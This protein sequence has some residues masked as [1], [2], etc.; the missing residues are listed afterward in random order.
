MKTQKQIKTPKIP[1]AVLDVLGKPVKTEVFNS[2]NAWGFSGWS[3]T[4]THFENPLAVWEVGRASTRH[5]G[6][7]PHKGVRVHQNILFEEKTFLKGFKEGRRTRM[8]YYTL[9]HPGVYPNHKI[10]EDYPE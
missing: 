8:D 5:C 9:A 6:T 1:Q 3:G 2:N 10:G 7:F 4:V